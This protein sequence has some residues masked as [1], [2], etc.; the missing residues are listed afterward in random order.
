MNWV[1][2]ALYAQLAEAQTKSE[3][4]EIAA[5]IAAKYENMIKINVSKETE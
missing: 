2:R 5:E 4:A 1:L 3:R